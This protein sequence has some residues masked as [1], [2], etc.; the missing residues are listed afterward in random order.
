[1]PNN[2][3][4]ETPA[5]KR[6]DRRQKALQQM[7]AEYPHYNFKSNLL[8]VLFFAG[9]ALTVWE[10]E[11]YR[12]TFISAKIL[13]LVWVL[14]GLLITP[15]FKNIFNIYCF[16]PYTPGRTPIFFYILF[17]TVSFGGILIFLFMFINQTFGSQ[18]KTIITLPIVSYG[19]FAKTG[20]NCGQP[21]ANVMYKGEEK[22]LVFYCGTEIKKY[23]SVYVEITKGLFGFEVITNKTLIEGQ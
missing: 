15:L 9:A 17:N 1:M 16:N 13:T 22:E 23:K 5:V 21:Y 4:R 18:T 20:K 12:V 11:I 6:V 3:N 7:S 10:I 8:G 2:K 19:H 14:T